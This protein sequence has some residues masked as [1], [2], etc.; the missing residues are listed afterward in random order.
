MRSKYVAAELVA[1]WLGPFK[2]GDAELVV[3]RQEIAALAHL[4]AIQQ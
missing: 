1:D 4:Q 3:V 2:I